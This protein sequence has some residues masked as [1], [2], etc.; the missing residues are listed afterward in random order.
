MDCVLSSE[1]GE[2]YARDMAKKVE[3]FI[4]RLMEANPR[5]S[6]NQFMH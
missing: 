4:G 1:D 6:R 5:I 2:A 3:N